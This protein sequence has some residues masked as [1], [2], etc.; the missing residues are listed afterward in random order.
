MSTHKPTT[1]LCN[2]A[3]AIRIIPSSIYSYSPSFLNLHK[4]PPPNS[5]SATTSISFALHSSDAKLRGGSRRRTWNPLAQ[6][7][8]SSLSSDNQTVSVASPTTTDA[9]GERV[10]DSAADIVR[11]FYGGINCHDLDSVQDLIAENCVYEDL[12]FPQPFVGR[13]FEVYY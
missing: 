2:P 10:V 5:A 1:L 4:T 13:K 3:S 9:D 7:D 12:I 11:N 8:G 6:I